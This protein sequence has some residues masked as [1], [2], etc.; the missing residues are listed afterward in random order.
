[1]FAEFVF[2][3]WSKIRFCCFIAATF[4]YN[5]RITFIGIFGGEKWARVTKRME[6]IV[7]LLLSS[8]FF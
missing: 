7:E 2:N 1:M 3:L 4:T 8:K 5:F 6:T